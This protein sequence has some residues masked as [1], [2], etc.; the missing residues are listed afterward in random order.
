MAEAATE[1]GSTFVSLYDL[2][3]GPNHDLDPLESG[4]IGPTDIDSYVPWYRATEAGSELIAER[5]AEE[6]FEPTP[7]P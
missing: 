5:L 7:Q 4:Y 1:H 6:G 2:F 3:N